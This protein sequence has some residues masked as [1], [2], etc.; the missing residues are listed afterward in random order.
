[1]VVPYGTDLIFLFKKRV[2]KLDPSDTD[3]ETG[4]FFVPCRVV[5]R[6]TYGT[7]VLLR[8]KYHKIA[9]IDVL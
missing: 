5:L 9:F 1:M 8:V 2:E 3:S 4:H 7:D 6:F